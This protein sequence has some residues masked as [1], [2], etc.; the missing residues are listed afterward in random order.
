MIQYWHGEGRMELETLWW[1]RFSPPA[2]LWEGRHLP[3]SHRSE[4]G[5]LNLPPGLNSP[6]V[7]QSLGDL[8]QWDGGREHRLPRDLE[9]K[10]RGREGRVY[11][12][13][14]GRTRGQS[15]L[16]WSQER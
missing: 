11:G 1:S 10:A 9:R 12:K 6:P 3:L 16:R 7:P 15:K 2:G 13:S 8:A 5:E 4:V 14:R